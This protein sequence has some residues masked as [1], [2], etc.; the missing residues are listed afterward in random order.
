MTLL[1]CPF[2]LFEYERVVTILLECVLDSDDENFV[3][4]IAV[5]LLNSMAS[6][7]DKCQKLFLGDIGTITV[8]TTTSIVAVHLHSSSLFGVVQWGRRRRMM[9]F[10]MNNL[11]LCTHK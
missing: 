9:R 11:I 2:Q 1:P 3:Q 4:R 7:V 10:L 8:S 6:R 5:F